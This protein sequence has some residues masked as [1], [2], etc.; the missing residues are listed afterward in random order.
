MCL[1]QVV[2]LQQCFSSEP[3]PQSWSPLHCRMLGMQILPWS[4]HMNWS[5]L[6]VRATPVVQNTLDEM[7]H[8]HTHSTRQCTLNTPLSFSHIS[9][10]L[11]ACHAQQQYVHGTCKQRNKSLSCV[12]IMNAWT[13][14]DNCNLV[15]IKMAIT[16]RKR[17]LE[18]SRS[19]SEIFL[20]FLF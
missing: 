18:K 14:L 1:K 16:F 3:S 10:L 5:G 13:I 12:T 4:S 9:C 15:K 8:T 20:C 11:H 6:Q 7:T 19:V 2:Y 17:D